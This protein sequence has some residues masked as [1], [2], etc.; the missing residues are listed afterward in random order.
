MDDAESAEQQPSLQERALGGFCSRFCR[1]LYLLFMLALF[2]AAVAVL[3]LWAPPTPTQ[4]FLGA[5]LFALGGCCGL[6][7]VS[8]DSVVRSTRLGCCCIY[9]TSVVFCA[10]LLG[11]GS[12]L[13]ER[14]PR[15][16]REDG[17][18]LLGLGLLGLLFVALYALAG[19]RAAERSRQESG[20]FLGQL[21]SRSRLSSSSAAVEL[22]KAL[23]TENRAFAPQ[24]L[25]EDEAGSNKVV[26]LCV[27]HS[28]AGGGKTVTFVD[29]E[30]GSNSP[31]AQDSEYLPDAAPLPDAE[32]LASAKSP[33][34][35]EAL[36]SAESATHESS[37]PPAV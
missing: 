8:W 1:G 18:I 11:A 19:R 3:V 14:T 2:G 10:G 26:M 5:V 7:F 23:F 16:V 35:T 30:E 15:Y 28:D 31:A 33:A 9:A 12:L 6:V 24:R 27:L 37:D 20:S 25:Q 34:A 4:V 36:P 22:C 21:T 13:A 17:L 29:A 32:S